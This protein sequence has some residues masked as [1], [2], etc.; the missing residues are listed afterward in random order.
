[1]KLRTTTVELE[2]EA[3]TLREHTAGEDLEVLQASLTWDSATGRPKPDLRKLNVKTLASA[4]QEW[5]L[6]DEEGKPL[7]ITEENVRQLPRHIFYTLLA[8]VGELNGLT[9]EETR[10]FLPA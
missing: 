4:L 1:M 2:G 10:A 3:F 6:K 9:P 8:K 5:S 7:P